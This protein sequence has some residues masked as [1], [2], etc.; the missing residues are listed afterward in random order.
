M[1]TCEQQRVAA[2]VEEVV[3]DPDL[4]H[5]EQLAPER[6]DAPF[7]LGGRGGIGRFAAAC[8]RRCPLAR[9]RRKSCEQRRQR[10]LRRL[11]KRCQDGAQV[12]D[13]GLRSGQARRVRRWKSRRRWS[14]G[15]GHHGQRDRVVRRLRRREQID[16]DLVARAGAPLPRRR[17]SG[18]R[19]GCRRGA[20]ARGSPAHSWMLSSGA[21][22]CW[23]RI[24]LRLLQLPPARRRPASAASRRTRTG[25]LF[26]QGPTIDS[27]PGSSAGRPENAAPK[28]TSSLAAPMAEQEGPR[29]LHER[30]QRDLAVA[31]Q[32]QQARRWPRPTELASSFAGSLVGGGR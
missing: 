20:A 2:E 11:W 18:R 27:M 8:R 22:W 1:G 29:P 30:A 19:A 10:R 14:A 12:G 4:V 17:S 13:H 32:R 5:L 21:Y 31:G 25:R 9:R 26:T 16:L 24:G 3:V 28:V 23:R 15:P 6:R 7:H